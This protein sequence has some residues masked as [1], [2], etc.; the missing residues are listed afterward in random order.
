MATRSSPVSGEARDAARG[1]RCHMASL[2]YGD[3]G[4]SSN[5]ARGGPAA[6]V[7][8][9]A[10]NRRMISGGT[11]AGRS[12]WSK[13]TLRHSRNRAG[14]ARSIDH[15]DDSGWL[16]RAELAAL[17]PQ[18]VLARVKALKP[19]IAASAG[20]TER[21]RRPVRPSGTRCGA[22]CVLSFR[23]EAVRR[24]RVR[25]RDVPR[26]HARGR[27]SVRVH[28]LDRDLPIDHNWLASHFPEEAQHEFLPAAVTSVLRDLESDR[29]RRTGSGRL[30]T[31]RALPFRQR[32]HE[33]DWCSQW[34]SCRAKPRRRAGL[35]SRHAS[36]RARHVAR[37]RAG[38]DRQ[39]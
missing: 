25:R 2:T 36:R 18:E 28:L 15:P 7:A 39:Q 34:G 29:Q 30:P 4:V 17:T 10:S 24:S 35:R 32:G 31:E 13:V 11:S 22:R 20:E 38:R 5:R 23:P 33:R 12:E 19:Q 26:H 14:A 16:S 9:R 6:R 27:R 3:V 1:P 8:A 37:R 21:Q